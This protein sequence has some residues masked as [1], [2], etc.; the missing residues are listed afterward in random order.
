M[1][2]NPKVVDAINKQIGNEFGAAMQYVAIATYFSSDALPQ[3]AE[4]F[5]ARRRRKTNMPCA[6]S[7]TSS[8]PA[9]KL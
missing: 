9:A 8:M 7:N 6:S 2:T 5:S 4:H 3:L 1:L